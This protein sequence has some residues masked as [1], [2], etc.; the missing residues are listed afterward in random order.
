MR[1]LTSHNGLGLAFARVWPYCPGMMT[2]A[3]EVERSR[4]ARDL[5][6]TDAQIKAGVR[7][8]ALELAADVGQV[9]ALDTARNLA[10]GLLGAMYTGDA[11]P[12]TVAV[13]GSLRHRQ[14]AFARGPFARLHDSRL[15]E[16][17]GACSS[18]WWLAVGATA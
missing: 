14:H 5:S 1:F 10:Q 9:A 13:L 15:R 7:A 2:L 4:A 16:L 8:M 6:L 12:S 11:T 3:E 18:A 17:A